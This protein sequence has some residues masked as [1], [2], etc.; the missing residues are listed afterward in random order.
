MGAGG[1]L[2]RSVRYSEPTLSGEERREGAHKNQRG[3]A[4]C[5]PTALLILNSLR[6]LSYSPPTAFGTCG[7]TKTCSNIRYARPHQMRMEC[8]VRLRSR[9]MRL[10][11]TLP[12]SLP[13]TPC[14]RTH[15]PLP[16]LHPMPTYP[17]F[18]LFTRPLRT[19]NQHRSTCVTSCPRRA[20]RV[21][22]CLERVR[23]ISLR[24]ASRSIGSCQRTSA[25]D[26][27]SGGRVGGRHTGTGK[28]VG[29]GEL[30]DACAII[31][32]LHEPSYSRRSLFG[33]TLAIHTP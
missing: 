7:R 1:L 16:C 30:G 14:A 25:R 3:L 32:Y 33:C 28:V 21:R 13:Y 18:P 8:R 2:Y 6:S 20:L 23:T 10:R 17:P 24:C 27:E 4:G 15:Q 5:S 19:T 9:R 26:E 31:S 12:P 22:R 11:Y 29:G